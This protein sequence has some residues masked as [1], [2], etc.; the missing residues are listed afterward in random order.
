MNIIYTALLAFA[1]GFLV[2]QR[3][4]AVAVYLAGGALVFAFQSLNLLIE[5]TGGSEAAFGGPYPDHE[6]SK[7]FGYG[8]FNLVITLIG[9]GLV[10]IGAKVAAKRSRHRAALIEATPA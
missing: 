7:V 1:L 8:L 2:R 5:W 10:M 9:I 4:V 3:A 6:T